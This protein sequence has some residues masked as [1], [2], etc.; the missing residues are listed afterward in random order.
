MDFVALD[1]CVKDRN[2]QFIA[3]LTADDFLVLDNNRRRNIEFFSAD[4]RVPLA[5]VMLVDRSASMA[6]RKLERAKVAA[7]TFID[8]LRPEDL[9]E[10]VAFGDRADRRL[11]FSTD[12]ALAAQAVAEL[13]AH[14]ATA[15]FDSLAVAFRDLEHTRRRE[16]MDYRQAIIVLS[17]GEDTRSV[18]AFDD[19][20]EDARRSGVVVYGVSLRADEKGRALPTPRE[21]F[22]LAND[23]GGRALAVENPERL[24]PVYEEIGAELRHLYRL[25]FVAGDTPT[26]GSWRTISVRVPSNADAR[27]RTRAGYYAR[28]APARFGDPQPGK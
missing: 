20:L 18:L 4:G 17:D 16:A 14:G 9:L 11:A 1:V 22:Q 5:V 6:D 3:G 12:R 28:R 10:V 2:G 7:T 26:D 21:L 23:T 19:I 8:G 25:G 27:I 15:L 24:A 13:S